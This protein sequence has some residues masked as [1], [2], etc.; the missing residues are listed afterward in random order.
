[1]NDVPEV[2]REQL[3][4]G[5]RH[6]A[7]TVDRDRLRLCVS[8]DRGVRVDEWLL[9]PGDIRRHRRLGDPPDRAPDDAQEAKRYVFVAEQLD[10]LR[11]GRSDDHVIAR[12]RVVAQ[13]ERSMDPTELLRCQAGPP[14]ALV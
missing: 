9:D 4:E 14:A 13:A 6:A 3:R 2:T 10:R 7:P 1:A 11:A 5:L 12:V 8:E